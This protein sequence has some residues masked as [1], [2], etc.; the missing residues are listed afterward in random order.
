MSQPSGAQGGTRYPRGQG[1]G[2]ES[3][4]GGVEGHFFGGAGLTRVT[5][6]D[7]CG[8]WQT[9]TY[10][11]LCIGGAIGGGASGGVVTNMGGKSC[12]KKNYAGWF[13]ESGA[14]LGNRVAQKQGDGEL[15]VGRP[16]ACPARPTATRTGLMAP[17]RCAC[18]WLEKLGARV[19]ERHMDHVIGRSRRRS[20]ATAK[21]PTASPGK[22]SGH[23]GE[24]SY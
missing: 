11:K 1:P 5:C 20:M 2:Q 18:G 12:N 24:A 9:F 14:S 17:S 13:Y 7:E 10:I 22:R 6:Q 8:K 21:G 16:S 4:F 3:R 15:T 23:C 19:A